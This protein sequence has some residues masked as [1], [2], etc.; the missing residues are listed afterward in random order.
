MVYGVSFVITES[1]LG[2]SELV[3]VVKEVRSTLSA[4][5]STARNSSPLLVVTNSGRQTDNVALRDFL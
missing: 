5:S 3:K 4:T 1:L 2:L